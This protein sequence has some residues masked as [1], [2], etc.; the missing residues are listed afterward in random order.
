M[1]SEGVIKFRVEHETCVG[2][3]EPDILELEK[4]RSELRNLG[5]VGQDIT[6]YGGF[7]FGNLSRRMPDET[8]LITASQTGHLEHLTPEDYARVIDS[9]AAQNFVHSK[10]IHRPS[11]ETMTH[12]A[13]Y[14]SNGR[15]QF[16]FHV[17]CPEI[18][19]ARNDF[20]I[21]TTNQVVE[22]GTVEMFLEVQRLLEN[23][24]NYLKGVLAMGGHTD[25]LLAWG[26]T[27]DETGRHLL[28]LLSQVGGHALQP[29]L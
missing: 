7:G 15:I 3:S 12:V 11:S 22:F 24:E 8:F 18:W 10:G 1:S 21:P 28:S 13:V 19:T 4:W 16:V 25:G 14:Q 17:H 6:R 23:Q 20:D 29:A 26:E 5:L 27:A 9:D 2:C